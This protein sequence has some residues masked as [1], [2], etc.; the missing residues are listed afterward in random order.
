MKLFQSISI[1]SLL[2]VGINSFAQEAKATDCKILKDIK[3]R[4]TEEA[5]KNSYVIIQGNTHTEYVE[6]GKYIIKST[7]NWINDC[8]YDA[9]LI[10]TTIPNFLK[11]GVVMHVTF[12][13][14]EKGIVTGHASIDGNVFP[15]EFKI[16]K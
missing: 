1:V 2:F 3:M 10:E 5:N 8:E 12:E 15:V 4:Y 16:I 9:T 6:N 13:K 14:I 11:P 7:L